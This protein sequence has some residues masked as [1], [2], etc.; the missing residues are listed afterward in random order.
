[1]RLPNKKFATITITTLAV[2][3]N[4]LPINF[5]EPAAHAS[6][7]EL[8]QEANCQPRPN[9][10]LTGCDYTNQTLER[11]SFNGS[12]LTDAIFNGTKLRNVDFTGANLYG[13][14][15]VGV[16]GYDPTA[17]TNVRSGNMIASSFRRIDPNGDNWPFFFVNGYLVTD[18]VDLSGADLR[19]GDFS[20]AAFRNI[21]FEGANLSNADFTGAVVHD[22][23]FKD[24]VAPW[25][26][27]NEARFFN[28]DMSGADFSHAAIV[29]VSWL[30]PRF[31]SVNMTSANFKSSMIRDFTLKD[32]IIEGVDFEF[33]T[34]ENSS[35]F[36]NNTGE[37]S[38]QGANF[39][40]WS[41]NLF[42]P[43]S[44]VGDISLEGLDLRGRDFSGVGF[45][46]TSFR[47]ANLSGV[48]FVG[49]GIHSVD[50]TGA[51]L[52]NTDFTKSWLDTNVSGNQPKTDFTNA[53]L[54]GIK[55]SN[56][57]TTGLS[58]LPDGWKLRQGTFIGPTADI[59]GGIFSGD[60]LA[61]VDLS[62]A[63]LDY[64]NA[65]N[66]TGAPAKLPNGWIYV[67]NAL[68]GPG[69][70]L[71]GISLAN[72]D[73]SSADLTG[74][75]YCGAEGPAALPSGW[76]Y[77][78][79]CLYGPGTIVS[80]PRLD[81]SYADLRNARFLS[82]NMAGVNLTGAD[83]TG[84]YSENLRDG[85]RP[86]TTCQL[87]CTLPDGWT[88]WKGRLLGPGADLSG[89]NF[90]NADV[91]NLDLGSVTLDR[92]KSGGISGVPISLPE[93]WRLSGGYLLG[94][95]ADLSNATLQNLNL[96]GVDLS[97]AVFA[98]G[99]NYV[100]SFNLSGNPILPAG[101]TLKGGFFF[102]PGVYVT[103]RNM[104]LTG[105][106][107]TSLDLTQVNIDGGLT[108]DPLLPEGW[109]L[110]RGYLFG[111]GVTLAQKNLAGID[112]S[113]LN[114]SGA[115]LWSVNLER[116]NLSGTNL[117]N[118]VF[119]TTSFRYANLTGANLSN[120]SSSSVQVDF[121]Y[122]NLSE[123]S[124]RNAFMKRGNFYGATLNNV[125]FD[126]ATFTEAFFNLARLTNV[127]SSNAYLGSA[128][129]YCGVLFAGEA[130]MSDFTISDCSLSYVPSM[131]LSNGTFVR[132]R[133]FGSVFR[134]LTGVSF[135]DSEL[136]NLSFESATISNS[137]F[138]GSALVN[139]AF[140]SADV[141]NLNL[142]ETS[143]EGINL[144]NAK[145]RGVT[146]VPRKLD[147]GVVLANGFLIGPGVNLSSL[148]LTG[149]NLTG[150]NLSGVN[151]S[152]AVMAA[153]TLNAVRSG[154]NYQ[155][156]KSLPAGWKVAGGF[157]L[158][159]TAN[160]S[161]V[162]LDSV[163]V[164]GADL[165]Q[166]NLE[167]I[168]TS[169]LTGTPVGLPP[170]WMLRSGY[171]LGP[172]SNLSGKTLANIDLSGLNLNSA[173]LA[174]VQTSGLTGSA[175]ILPE[176]WQLLKG[177]LVGPGA[178]LSSADLSGLDLS[179]LT[180]TNTVL[181][182]A[183]LTNSDLSTTNL[184][185]A[186]LDGANLRGVRSGSI[187]G[188]PK[189]L[190]SDFRFINGCLVGPGFRSNRCDLNGG[191]I[192]GVNLSDADFTDLRSGNLV[193]E[194]YRMPLGTTVAGGYI[195]GPGVDLTGA[196]IEYLSFEG[197]KI[198]G[199]N[200]AG[201]SIG[202]AALTVTGEPKALPL[203]WKIV[204]LPS[205]N[206]KLL[207]T[208]NAKLQTL[209]LSGA[210]LDG[211]D[212]SSADL[213]GAGGS[214]ILGTPTHLPAGWRVI[215][216]SLIGP[217]GRAFSADMSRSS[218]SSSE[219]ANTYFEDSSLEGGVVSGQYLSGTVFYNCNLRSIDVH[220]LEIS[221]ASF[222]NSDARGANFSQSIISLTS[223]DSANLEGANLQNT[224]WINVN[225]SSAILTGA[226]IQGADFSQSNLS[227]VVTGGLVGTPKQLPS[228]YILQNGYVLRVLESGSSPSITGTGQVGTKLTATSAGW[229]EGVTLTYAWTLDGKPIVGETNSS[230]A[231]RVED[232]GKK[233]NAIVSG[234]M[235]GYAASSI[236]SPD[237]LVP[238]PLLSVK[239]AVISGTSKVGKTISV[240]VTADKNYGTK[241]YQWLLDGKVIKNA[242]K[243]SIKLLASQKGR[244]VSCRVTLT[245]KGSKSVSKTTSAV[246][247]G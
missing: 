69:A 118:A 61:N 71:N 67:S 80:P 201:A 103:L 242:T 137:S 4:L 36:L 189:T 155:Q 154:N 175:F 228:G 22:S 112:L 152:N 185:G 97:K 38:K 245:A 243:N 219:L 18:G 148:D 121:A 35:T 13:A 19:L 200:F 177:R 196:Q 74:I 158:G 165:S 142:D 186:V 52:T 60:S 227:G 5:I 78:Q 26:V 17:F 210:D 164:Q 104:N 33:A 39:E 2:L 218:F 111:P 108:G 12:N 144:S 204:R 190:P 133:I 163:N 221:N 167:G 101:F 76:L 114:L 183:N 85:D 123:T 159:P 230:Y 8:I 16:T 135:I 50:F 125:D 193:G 131:T 115:K 11:V 166:A 40:I 124:F 246:K 149:F 162:N 226:N 240:V 47:G 194:P 23:S 24:A 31:E 56:I 41:E 72:L 241:T 15:W 119:G 138:Q 197:L 173:N 70:N 191:D 88:I 102:G 122:A 237:Y 224:N 134:K 82:T 156:P 126:D 21:S 213:T 187:I 184:E 182:Y 54:T 51:N 170:G 10:D 234:S 57:N 75:N 68:V 120:S 129:S 198:D 209:N 145:I 130:E 48:K 59:S 136:N 107:L 44:I 244:K 188:T 95:T 208:P 49:S 42:R 202:A 96:D 116:A 180:L 172:T 161:S 132:S 207:L 81:L 98:S 139:P 6:T 232:I 140:M 160:L 93:G 1:L 178:N 151:L 143:I 86:L 58:T 32:C 34:W 225:F 83:L 146:G 66:L 105:V 233:I 176:Y 217:A 231:V 14:T 91:S 247:V 110:R 27:L 77:E 205:D 239:N 62:L 199:I 55:S 223:L 64:V 28:V 29:Y 7:P 37:V 229:A 220:D 168:V 157:L 92:V 203:G 181:R 9:A 171:L 73:L 100:K 215:Q 206:R 150:A 63:K 169:R 153:T 99:L 117:S 214:G 45:V 211:V 195:I 43:G 128:H 236:K 46:G 216:G 53:N 94:P 113:Q 192:S 106:D 127:T 109:A 20:Y 141:Q 84:V 147:S 89:A 174:G 222:F 79:G 25:T 212:L 238:F 179:N 30:R 3:A 235:Q 90:S 87:T 65:R